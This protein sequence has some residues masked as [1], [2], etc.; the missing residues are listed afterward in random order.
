MARNSMY[1][2]ANNGDT[3]M[4]GDSGTTYSWIK[5]RNIA[6]HLT[7]RKIDKAERY[8]LSAFFDWLK[9]PYY[10]DTEVFGIGYTPNLSAI[11]GSEYFYYKCEN[12]LGYNSP[13]TLVNKYTATKRDVGGYGFSFDL[14][15]S[16][17]MTTD[18]RNHR[19]YM[20]YEAYITPTVFNGYVKSFANY[21]HQEKTFSITPTIAFPW[22]G[23]LNLNYANDFTY[24]NCDI[25]WYVNVD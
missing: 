14:I 1:T 3:S 16:D 24:A 13:T 22:G 6:T 5:I 20:T 15:E 10:R 17:G 4:S 21:A 19:G 12:L 18:Y 8:K 9:E 23:A 2:L 11:P 25:Q 7:R